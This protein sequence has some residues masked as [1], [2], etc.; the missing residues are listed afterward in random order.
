MARVMRA[1]RGRWLVLIDI[2]VPRDINPQV[3]QLSNVY[4]YDIDSLSAVVSGNLSD[5]SRAAESAGAIV[6]GAAE[7]AGA[8][9]QQRCRAGHSRA[10]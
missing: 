6:Q 4:L 10:A 1:R 2:A 5:R 7:G 8:R 3:G 9:P